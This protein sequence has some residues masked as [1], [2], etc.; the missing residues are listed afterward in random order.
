MA[1]KIEWTD[2]VWNPVTGCTKVSDGCKNCY[3]ERMSKRLAGRFGY[4]ADVPFK[5]TLHQDKLN[6]P[7][8]WKKPRRVFVNSMSDLFHKDI[9]FE[10]VSE[11]FMVMALNQQHTFQIL[12]KRPDRMLKYFNKGHEGIAP[13]FLAMGKTINWLETTEKEALTDD[14]RL[15]WPLENVWIG[16]SVEN[17]QAANV[18]I[19]MLLQTPAKVRFLSMEPLLE[20]VDL[21]AWIPPT[22]TRWKCSYCGAWS[23]EYSLH[24]G[25]CGKEGGYSGSYAKPDWI[26]VGGESGPGARPMHPDWV[27]D[28][29]DQCIAANVPF[30]LK[31][32]GEW[33]PFHEL[34]ANEP[35]I[36]GK[37]WHNFDPDTSVCKVGK[38]KAGRILDGRTW[39][40]FPEVNR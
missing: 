15:R 4:P 16:V 17:Q 28:I 29:R 27:I 36:A 21:S 8:K 13:Y 34:R 14:I 2:E 39:D 35:G 9:P 1:S 23:E 32:W 20:S 3:A 11:M 22:G 5:V 7:F 10:F 38:K 33:A 24:C 12:T 6:D 18:R 40:K 37:A 31:Q 19:P 30:L 26:I 25:S